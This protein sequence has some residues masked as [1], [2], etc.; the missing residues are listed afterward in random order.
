MFMYIK[1]IKN[2]SY[3]NIFLKVSIK[4]SANIPYQQ[5]SMEKRWP[6]KKY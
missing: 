3:K 1:Y 6:K 5:N 4:I 2:N